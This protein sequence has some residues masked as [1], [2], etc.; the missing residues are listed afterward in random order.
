MLA[1]R[2]HIEEYLSVLEAQ[3]RSVFAQVEGISTERLWRR[4]PSGKWSAGEHQEHLLKTIRLFRRTFR[5]LIPFSLPIARSLRSSPYT[6][7]V[8]DVFEG[9]PTK[10]PFV[11]A[12]RH[13]KEP[14]DYLLLS[15]LKQD[16]EQERVRLKQL[17]ADLDDEVAGHIKMW[18]GSLGWI[19]LLQ[20]L[21]TLVFH[22]EHHF[23]A[24][25]SLL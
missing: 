21:Q 13:R 15:S 2:K 1:Q 7:T 19:N 22:E 11:I 10:A 6:A 24:I 14:K 4:P 23:K 3:R 25:R 9:R 5:V 16:L 20:E 17:F 12:P 18:G 8:P